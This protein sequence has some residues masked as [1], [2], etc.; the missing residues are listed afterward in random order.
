MRKIFVI[1]QIIVIVCVSSNCI[2]RGRH[3]Y[4]GYIYSYEGNDVYVSEKYIYKYTGDTNA[5]KGYI[6]T[7]EDQRM[8]Q[9]LKFNRSL[10]GYIY[11][12]GKRPLSDL[13]VYPRDCRSF[14]CTA[15][16]S[17]GGVTDK[18]GY[19]KFNQAKQWITIYLMI[20]SEGKNIDSIQ[21]SFTTPYNGKHSMKFVDGRVDTFWLYTTRATQVSTQTDNCNA[22]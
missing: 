1:I 20:E 7:I 17:A 13:R 15:T 5:L 10:G 4:E 3:Y 6:D 18:N 12:T 8:I 19:F 22:D 2:Q 21:V 16:D 11:V 14:R 9:D